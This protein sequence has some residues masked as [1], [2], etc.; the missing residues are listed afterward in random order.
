MKGYVSSA[1]SVPV[2]VQNI[3]VRDYCRRHGIEYE[4]SAVENL[5]GFMQLP[6]EPIVCYSLA[7]FMDAPELLRDGMHFAVEDMRADEWTP[8]LLKLKRILG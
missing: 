3:V 6:G 7:Q 5:Q 4:L 2:H 8:L 1:L